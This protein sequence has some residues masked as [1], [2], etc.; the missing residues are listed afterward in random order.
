MG[1]MVNLSKENELNMRISSIENGQALTL[2]E[3]ASESKAKQR[4]I[5]KVH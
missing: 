5:T 4:E 2:R 1:L 3:I